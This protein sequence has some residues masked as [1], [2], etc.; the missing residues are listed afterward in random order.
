MKIFK[1]SHSIISVLSVLVSSLSF[2]LVFKVFDGGSL[3]D[4]YYISLNMVLVGNMIL[5]LLI[6]Q[7][8]IYF[9]KKINSIDEMK[10]Y[11]SEIIYFFVALSVLIL[12]ISYMVILPMLH[13][14]SA[15]LKISSGVLD[16]FSILMAS[17]STYLPWAIMQH[18]LSS[19]G[20]IIKSYFL[21][22]TPNFILLINLIMIWSGFIEPSI[23][24]ICIVY[25]ISFFITCILGII[26][27]KDLFCHP[28]KIFTENVK[29]LVLNSFK[30]RVSTNIHNVFFNAFTIYILSDLKDGLASIFYLSKRIGD[31]LLTIIQGPVGKRIQNEIVDLV[32]G[33]NISGLK[34]LHTRCVRFYLFS[35]AFSIFI[36]LT[37]VYFFIV[38][39][40]F[41]NIPI[42]Q[43]KILM[44]TLAIILVSNSFI[45]LESFYHS[46]N[47]MYARYRLI[48]M[49]NISFVCVILLLWINPIINSIVINFTISI[50]CGQF[51]ILIFHAISYFNCVLKVERNC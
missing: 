31:V 49:A 50:L 1:I 7:F 48:A 23:E 17:F 22:I 15:S 29:N 36:I 39:F 47:Q 26:L 4:S 37:F 11:F 16:N 27:N 12:F 41:L 14:F 38:Y 3:S 19:R 20:E 2:G 21:F 28:K 5:E 9:R 51:L 42:E 46:Y 13:Y 30:L 8:P 24:Y 25:V 10:A 18:A 45:C 40:D 32:C 43:E 34:V 33:K 44:T 35:N 6:A